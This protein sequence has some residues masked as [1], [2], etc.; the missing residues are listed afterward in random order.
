[1][2]DTHS[3]GHDGKSNANREPALHNSAE[4]WLVVND[5]EQGPPE[6]S[7]HLRNKSDSPRERVKRSITQRVKDKFRRSKKNKKHDEKK[8]GSKDSEGDADDDLGEIAEEEIK[9]D[10]PEV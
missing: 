3:T 1:M 2:F 5:A 10:G 8:R 7:I 4:D 6:S 9:L